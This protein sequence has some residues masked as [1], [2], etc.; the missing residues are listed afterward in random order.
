MGTR[1]PDAGE[2]ARRF[3]AIYTGAL[4]DVL[5]GLGRGAQSLPPAVQALEAGARLAGPAFT[6]ERRPFVPV[7]PADESRAW[8]VFRALPSDHVAVFVTHS[9]S[10]AVIGDLAIA[11]M[12]VRGCAGLVVDGG[13]RDVDAL[14]EIGLPVFCRH[15]TPQDVSHGNGGEFAHGHDV[16]VGE[17]RIA[18]GDYIVGDADGVV[19]IPQSLVGEVLARAEALVEAELQIRA[20]ILAGEEPEDAYARFK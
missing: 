14:H 13:V 18:V 8:D 4:T 6:Y 3:G 17:V 1:N 5:Y 16:V 11:F 12:Q 9:E 10:R 15:T 19:V 7:Q 20:A 2:L